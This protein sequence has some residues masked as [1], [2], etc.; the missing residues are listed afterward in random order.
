MVATSMYG[1]L[2]IF[3]NHIPVETIHRLE[4]IHIEKEPPNY[5][6]VGSEPRADGVVRHS[7]CTHR[8]LA[9]IDRDRRVE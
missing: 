1:L 6:T 2:F 3:I 9:S 5:D 7:V 4:R 8:M